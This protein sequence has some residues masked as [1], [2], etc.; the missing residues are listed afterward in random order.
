MPDLL[1]EVLSEEIPARMQAGGARELEKQVCSRLEEARLAFDA[2]QVKSFATPRRLALMVPGLPDEQPDITVERKGPRVDAPDKAIQGFLKSTGLTLD[3]CE[4]RETPK[5]PVWFAV[6]QEKGRPTGDLLAD[7]LPQALAAVSWPKSMRWEESGTRW[8]RP[9]RSILCLLDDQVVPF[10][11]GPVESGRT[12]LGHRFLSSGTLTI[13]HVDD[14]A[15]TL[16]DAKVMLDTEQRAQKIEDDANALTEGSG[17]S[18]AEDRWL[19]R[20]NAGLAEWPVVLMGTIDKRFME[21]PDLILRSA[22]RTHQ[23]YFSVIGHR[24]G[25]RLAPHFVMV[26]DAEIEGGSGAVVTGNERVL[27]ARLAD[28][29]FFWDQDGLCRLEDRVDALNGMVFH[30]RLGSMHQKAKRIERLARALCQWIEGADPDEAARAGLLCK[31]DLMTETVGEFPDLQGV[32]GGKLGEADQERESVFIAILQ[33][34]R[35]EGPDVMCPERPVSVVVALADKLDTLA[36]FFAIDERPT[37]SKDPFALR[38]SALS[39]IRLIVENKLRL[40][41]GEALDTALTGYGWLR[42]GESALAHT[43]AGTDRR[44]MLPSEPGKEATREALL[45]FFADRVRAHLREQGIRH[46]LV[47]AVFGVED[48][49]DLVRLL[50]RIDALAGFL[51]TLDGAN[52]LIA[53][54]RAANI[55]RIEEKKDGR[56]YEGEPDPTLFAE[57]DERALNEQIFKANQL[58]E[59][60]LSKEAFHHTVTIMAPLR[61]AVDDFFDNVTV[62]CDDPT[63]RRNRLLML[64]QIRATLDRVAD[65]SKIEG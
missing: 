10:R 22:M 51:N 20:E 37:G 12:T 6:K 42:P 49:D 58:A 53:Y 30:A 7:L 46:D 43:I 19:R 5:G 48:E 44:T 11:F 32:M 57:E 23:R 21:L 54:R 62:N 18:L 31:A 61:A 27:R 16:E 36:G 34:Y 9:I 56:C 13:E 1:L 50:A 35:P 63:L 65:F 4:Q 41:L 29:R 60:M 59:H 38:R 33:H 55:L 39:V 45:A 26:S 3:D 24:R 15:T 17:F 25:S 52:L 47:N 14:Y 8:V 2:D 28:A 40:P 64:S